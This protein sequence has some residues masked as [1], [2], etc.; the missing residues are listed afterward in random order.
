MIPALLTSFALV[1]VAELG[2]K[3]Q[4]LVAWL[5]SRYR[6][7]HVMAGVVLGSMAIHGLA[8]LAGAVLGAL[9]PMVAVEIAAGLLFLGFAFLA[10]RGASDDDEARGLGALD[11]RPILGTAAVFFVAELGDKTQLMVLARA[12]QESADSGS[13]IAIMAAVWVGAVLAMVAADGLAILAGTFLGAR[14]RRR[15]LALISAAL[16]AGFGLFSLGR[17]LFVYL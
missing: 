13:T 12:A 10:L 11:R 5:A 15:T 1:F 17:V 2:D 9:V 7:W 6:P 4:V 8:V 16:F 14:M 3:T